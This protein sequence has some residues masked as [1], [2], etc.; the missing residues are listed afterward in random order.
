MLL[1]TCY[2]NG[3]DVDRLSH[4]IAKTDITQEKKSQE[5]RRL[6]SGAGLLAL[7]WFDVF[8]VIN[9]ATRDRVAAERA[10]EVV[11]VVDTVEVLSKELAME[12]EPLV[13]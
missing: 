11:L 1:A 10:L 8:V 13:G 7:L 5:M 9:V 3:C 12:V 6:V 2:I 4:R